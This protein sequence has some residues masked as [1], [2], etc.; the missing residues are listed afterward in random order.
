[1]D[2]RELRH[3]DAVA[4]AIAA[5]QLPDRTFVVDGRILTLDLYLREARD[6]APVQVEAIEAGL[7]ELRKAEGTAT[8][9]TKPRDPHKSYTVPGTVDRIG[10]HP[11][12]AAVFLA[13]LAR[14]TMRS[15]GL[16]ER[17]EIDGVTMGLGDALLALLKRH[18]DPASEAARALRMD[19]DGNVSS[20][21][22]ALLERLIFDGVL[23]KPKP[24]GR[25]SAAQE[26]RN[27]D[28]AMMDMN[29]LRS[30][31]LAR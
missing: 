21:A 13:R 9:G 4:S 23:S 29:R 8:G 31:A 10:E 27:T 2:T 17:V 26:R 24:D 20:V 28:D 14:S 30:G 22:S 19:A 6:D 7:R 12:S 5:G 15:E 25:S 3:L 18:R 16:P 11:S 1:M